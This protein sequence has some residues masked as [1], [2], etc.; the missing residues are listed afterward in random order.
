MNTRQTPFSSLL[1]IATATY[2]LVFAV[3]ADAKFV[4]LFFA[5]VSCPQ[6]ST[7]WLRLATVLPIVNYSASHV[8]SGRSDWQQ[9]WG[10][11]F[12]SKQP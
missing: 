1:V 3:Y 7:K 9:V 11:F 5:L 2:K 6:T 12:L 4:C 10:L 8:M